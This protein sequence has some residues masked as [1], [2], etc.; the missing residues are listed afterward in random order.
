MNI[1][2]CRHAS[3]AASASKQQELTRRARWQL[4]IH[5]LICRGCRVYARQVEALG[6]AMSRIASTTREG[7]PT[8]L[9]AAARER[10]R[11]VLEREMSR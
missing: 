6:H 2:S 4:G 11:R 9:A 1:F 7:L 10:I 5:R 8:P 3:E